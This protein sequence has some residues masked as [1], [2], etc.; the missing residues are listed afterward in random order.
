MVE[1]SFT[2]KVNREIFDR[3]AAMLRSIEIDLLAKVYLADDALSAKA[4]AS[5]FADGGLQMGVAEAVATHVQSP[6][7]HS[8]TKKLVSENLTTPTL[9]AWECGLSKR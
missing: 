6:D 3:F 7:S 2:R 8:A 1:S 4:G 9:R 5:F